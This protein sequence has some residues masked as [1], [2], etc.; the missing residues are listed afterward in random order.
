MTNIKLAPEGGSVSQLDVKTLTGKKMVVTGKQYVLACGGIENPRIL[1]Y[2]NDVASAGVGNQNDLVGRYFMDHLRIE[3]G[4]MVPNDGVSLNLYNDQM[5]VGID[6]SACIYLTPAAQ[7]D[8]KTT[9][10]RMKIQHR[11]AGRM[12]LGLRGLTGAVWDLKK[13]NVSDMG[14][15]LAR[16]LADPDGLVEGAIG[17]VT[18][19]EH[20]VC[21]NVIEQSPNP[22]SRVSLTTDKDA[23][24]LPR[25]ALDWQ[26]SELERGTLAAAQSAVKKAFEENKLGEMR[27]ELFSAGANWDGVDI[28]ANAHP[29]TAFEAG[30][31][32]TER[33]RW[34]AIRSPAWSMPIARFLVSG[35]SMWREA[36]SSRR[37]A[38][39]TRPSP[40]SP[41]PFAWPIIFPLRLEEGLQV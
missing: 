24:G 34:E 4:V 31:H 15:H 21:V 25:I 39:P 37:S 32:H 12:Q 17:I 33:P 40:S 28:V 9:V 38:A 29:S 2:S 20:L 13:G 3:S 8:F 30:H 11:K 19:R 6:R 1:L 26:L 14:T 18:K 16:I 22:D 23:L 36:P 7:R 5:P 10:F 27:P 35:T 41:W